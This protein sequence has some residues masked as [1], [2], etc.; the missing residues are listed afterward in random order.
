MTETNNVLNRQLGGYDNIDVARAIQLVDKDLCTLFDRPPSGTPTA[1]CIPE[2][3]CHQLLSLCC[4]LSRFWVGVF[5]IECHLN[6]GF[7]FEALDLH[8]VLD[9]VVVGMDMFMQQLETI[10]KGQKRLLLITN[11]LSP[12]RDPDQGTL[13]DQ[14]EIIG[15]RLEEHGMSLD[16]IHIS[17]QDM[18]GKSE[19]YMS[20][21]SVHFLQALASRSHGEME[22]VS[23]HIALMASIRPRVTATTLYRGD[24]EL[25]PA[26]KLKVHFNP[27]PPFP[28]CYYLLYASYY[29]YSTTEPT[30]LAPSGVGVQK[31]FSR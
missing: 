15:D 6:G 28:P 31:G 2:R 23:S 8:P 18:Q 1:D 30:F 13:Q 24:L 20:S 19:N 16:V 4:R 5:S 26:L 14:V 17:A 12:L 11:A 27:A 9:A 21:R 29:H 25:T 7:S 10:R 22:V 3:N